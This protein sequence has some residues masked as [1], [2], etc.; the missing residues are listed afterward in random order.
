MSH[1]AQAFEN[2]D[3][4]F[5]PMFADPKPQR[6]PRIEPQRTGHDLFRCK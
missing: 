4:S 1:A 6:E 5:R 3:R 2:C